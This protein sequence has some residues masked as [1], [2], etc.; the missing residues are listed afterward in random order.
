MS[1]FGPVVAVANLGTTL[2]QTLASGAR[3]L[4]LLDE[5]PQTEE[6]AD[7]A[8]LSGFDGASARRVGFSYGGAQVLQ[9]VDVEVRP[10]EVV[11]IAGRSGAG[12]STLL[13]LFM[14]FWDAD[15]GVVEVSGH[16]IRRVNTASLRENEG[17]MTQETH[18][19]EGTLRENLMLAGDYDRIG[20]WTKDKNGTVMLVSGFGQVSPRMK[21]RER[22]QNRM[23]EYGPD[24]PYGPGGPYA[25]GQRRYRAPGRR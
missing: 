2:Q 21:V 20:N 25:P 9:D 6:V 7:G 13:K 22:Q 12:K 8:D 23:G 3:V 17:F 4:D 14:R 18:L 16:D 19:F 5:E 10:G 1:S 24:M 15:K 11:R